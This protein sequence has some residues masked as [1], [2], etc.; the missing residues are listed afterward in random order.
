MHGKVNVRT[1]SHLQRRVHTH[2]RIIIIMQSQLMVQLLT[3]PHPP[4]PPISSQAA[5][6]GAS[7]Y[8]SGIMS[9]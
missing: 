3:F 5:V 1:N 8:I 6:N 2:M 9:T 4:P 7:V